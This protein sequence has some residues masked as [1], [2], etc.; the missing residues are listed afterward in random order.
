MYG[1]PD[2][3]D[4]LASER[5]QW[6]GDLRERPYE[7]S[8]EVGKGDKAFHG[9]LISNR[10]RNISGK[11][12]T[13][14]RFYE[15]GLRLNSGR[16]DNTPQIFDFLRREVAFVEVQL[17][18]IM[19]QAIEHSAEIAEMTREEFIKDDYIIQIN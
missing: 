2:E 1:L 18:L 3:V 19:S 4:F 7:T 11:R 16:S 8:I 17:T 6:S 10:R 9:I 5:Y 14:D 15:C 13:L 12:E